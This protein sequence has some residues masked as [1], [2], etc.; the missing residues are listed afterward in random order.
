MLLL[1]QIAFMLSMSP[2]ILLLLLSFVFTNA[3]GREN[4][5]TNA[6]GR[7]EDD[8]D[9]EQKGQEVH[10]WNAKAL[11]P[12]AAFGFL[13]LSKAYNKQQAPNET[14]TVVRAKIEPT[15]M[16]RI[17]SM[18]R[19]M[20]LDM[21]MTLMWEDQRIRWNREG[22]MTHGTNFIFEASILE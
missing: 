1:T 11:T 2:P 13:T 16:T 14:D 8:V 20:S 17:D 19:R 22:L 12:E 7:E 5:F 10:F 21:K 15:S 3:E 9:W 4:V 6:E 18:T